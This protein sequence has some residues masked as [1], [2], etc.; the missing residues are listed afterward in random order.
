MARIP[1]SFVQQLLSQLDIVECVGSRVSLKRAGQSWTARCPFHQ[2]KTPSFSVSSVKQFYHCFGCGAHGDAIRFVMEMDGL[3]FP[4]AVEKLAHQIGLEVPK[5]AMAQ[6]KPET[7]DTYAILEKAA[8]WFFECLTGVNAKAARAYCKKRG[9]TES[10]IE[11]FK[12]GYAPEGWDGLIKHFGGPEKAPI[13]LLKQAGLI[14]EHESGRHY[15]RFRDRL[16]FPIRDRRGRVI[17]FGGRAFGDAKPKYLNSPE[18][19]VFHKRSCLYGVF[20]AQRQR[21]AWRRAV[22]V[23]GY[24]DVIALSMNGIKGAFATLGTALT[25]DHLKSLFNQTPELVFCFD[26]DAAGRKAAWSAAQSLLPFMEGD[27]Q[28]SFLFLPSGEDPDSFLKQY[29]PQAFRHEAKQAFPLSTFIFDTLKQQFDPSSLDAKARYVNAAQKLIGSIPEGI[30]RRLMQQ[31]LK[32]FTYEPFNRRK[33]KAEEK[34]GWRDS[35]PRPALREPTE[36]AMALLLEQPALALLVPQ[37]EWLERISQPKAA[38]LGQLIQ[39]L[40]ADP[41]ADILS[42]KQSLKQKVPSIETMSHLSVL[43]PQAQ[44]AEFLGIVERLA[45]MGKQ[46]LADTLIA[47]SKTKEGLTQAQKEQLKALLSSLEKHTSN[48]N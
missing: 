26:A 8:S 29:G 4:E 10:A 23:E 15:D 5:E 35:R 45:W 30:Y 46:A 44:E 31:A 17:A 37:T 38:M 20:E 16:I 27:R 42:L 14:I 3:S 39:Q 34:E 43:E 22:I 40:K 12:I 21:R 28:A 41:Q 7:L 24:M 9:L 2:E 36:V 13:G 6:P 19:V 25:E 11:R 33:N 48:P 1:E 32:D 47:Q 18:S